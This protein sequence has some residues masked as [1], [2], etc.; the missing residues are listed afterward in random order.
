[1]NEE[2]LPK[3]VKDAL[4]ELKKET[5]ELKGYCLLEDAVDFAT[6]LA[7]DAMYA[8]E[9]AVDDR[10]QLID[11]DNQADVQAIFE[12]VVENFK[13][14]QA[15]AE[16]KV[17]RA[18]RIVNERLEVTGIDFT[19]AFM[20]AINELGKLAGVAMSLASRYSFLLGQNLKNHGHGS[21]IVR[22]MAKDTAIVEEIT[23]RFPKG[24][25]FEIISPADGGTDAMD[26]KLMDSAKKGL[27]N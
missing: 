4:E 5:D 22:A 21:V 26:Q 23:S 24:L 25:E 27:V 20:D 13:T 15:Q 10:I 3:E 2:D 14:A 7:A 11:M 1:M 16:A 8:S 9:Q 6:A 12:G 18:R 19:N 17:D